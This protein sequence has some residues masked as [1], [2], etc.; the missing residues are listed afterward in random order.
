MRKKS[1]D[2]YANLLTSL[3][4]LYNSPNISKDEKVILL[5]AIADLEKGVY[6]N[7]VV[8]ELKRALMPK[9]LSGNISKEVLAFFTELS[10]R[11]FDLGPASMWNFMIRK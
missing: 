6:Y 3:K 11:E 9:A 7:R 8:A 4:E 2:K 5:S 10:R 1:K